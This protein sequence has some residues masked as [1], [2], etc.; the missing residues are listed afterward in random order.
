[1]VNRLFN[2][3]RVPQIEKHPIN[4]NKKHQ[5]TQA[6]VAR[7]IWTQHENDVRVKSLYRIPFSIIADTDQST[8]YKR[9]YDVRYD[10]K[11]TVVCV[12]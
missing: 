3:R 11:L 5:T 10:N 1:M 12:D 7:N 8:Y 2:S 6:P 4:E 9:L